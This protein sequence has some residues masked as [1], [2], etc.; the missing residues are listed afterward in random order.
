MYNAV[1]INIRT[2]RILFYL[3]F[4]VSSNK[5]YSQ[6]SSCWI[7]IIYIKYI[8]NRNI[9]K[10]FFMHNISSKISKIIEYY[11]T[12]VNNTNNIIKKKKKSQK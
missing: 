8:K 1:L 9:T 7:K 10:Q 3:K 2:S 6:T 12:N 5:H 11:T 4:H